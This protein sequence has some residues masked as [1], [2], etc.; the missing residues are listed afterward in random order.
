MIYRIR[1]MPSK[2]FKMVCK[3]SCDLWH[4]PPGVFGAE[5]PVGDLSSPPPEALHRA[6]IGKIQ[7][8]HATLYISLNGSGLMDENS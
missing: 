6:G 4:L 8:P 3:G 1:P 7:T 5:L 2:L